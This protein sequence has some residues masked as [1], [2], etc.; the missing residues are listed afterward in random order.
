MNLFSKPFPSFVVS[1]CFLIVLFFTPFPLNAVEDSALFAGGCFWCLEH[2]LEDINGVISA[3][4]G[5]SGGDLNKPNYQNHAGHQETV[6]VK[7]D[8]QKISYKK[9]LMSFWLNIDPFDDKGQFCDRGDSYK[10]LIFAKGDE[11]K[12]QALESFEDVAKKLNVQ[13]DQLKVQVKDVK[14]FWEAEEYHQDFAKRNALKYNFYR[15]SCG[16]DKRLSDI[17]GS[18]T[19]VD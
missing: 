9:I 18:A 7:F 4:S 2:D 6:L 15:Y 3:T 11:Q 16:R 14:I 12:K 1:L 8:P 5:Y 19:L 10:P 17:W 13:I